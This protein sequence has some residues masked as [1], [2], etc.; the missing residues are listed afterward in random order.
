[1]N[2]ED[3]K[4]LKHGEVGSATLVLVNVE[5]RETV[6]KTKFLNIT[7]SD[8][9]GTIGAKVWDWNSPKP[10]L[11]GEL[12]E[13]QFEFSP[14]KDTPQIV[15]R[16]FKLADLSKFDVG[17]FINTLS[18]EEFKFY[19]KE[20]ENLI[21]EIQDEKL[22]AFVRFIIFKH[23][24]EYKSSVGGKL[25][26]HS[27]LGGLM[28]HSVRVARSAQAI[29]NSYKDTPL[30]KLVDMDLLIAGALLHDL[31]KI[32]EYTTKGLSIDR[33]LEGNLT[34]HYDTGPAYLSEAYCAFLKDN[35]DM[36]IARNRILAI[37]HI[38]VTH[39]GTDLS[40][41]PPSM[42]SAWFIHSADLSDCFTDAI[43]DKIDSDN[44][45][46]SEN[47]WVIKHKVVNETLMK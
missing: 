34:T 33:S 36:N 15:I 29:A 18:Q 7:L 46:S 35:A 38:M 11:V 27:R 16:D 1:M 5:V 4:K 3:I 43:M 24:P 26:H 13:I 8:K 45:L 30:Y 20:L 14:Y 40:T 44:I 6:K 39:H 37:I 19:T 32:G 28:Q 21:K 22:R 10:P 2:V 25:N 31:G 41:N 23:F 9:T 12:W 47:V 17:L 42:I